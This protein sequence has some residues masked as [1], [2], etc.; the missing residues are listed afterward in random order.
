[1]TAPRKG[2]SRP[3]DVPAEVLARLN[4]GTLE[5]A[6]L[7][8]GLAMDFRT[9]LRAIEPQVSEDELAPLAPTVGISRRM[10][11]AADRLLNRRGPDGF[12]ALAVHP[13]D[14]V[15]GWAAY[16]LAR[17]PG[18]TLAERLEQLRPLA[19]DSHFG[20]REWAWLAMR[21]HLAADI[22]CSVRLLQ[23]WTAVASANLRR[24]AVESVRPCGVWCAHIAAL[25]EDPT[26]GLPLLE[27][28]KADRAKY[29]QD[30][31]AN[32]LNDAAKSKPDWVR[33]L[34][35][36]WRHDSPC[37]E[38]QRICHRAERSIKG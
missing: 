35:R 25:K 6:T 16:V 2:A 3:A 38:T 7:A 4:A 34:T 29:V 24:F 19:D 18:L 15:R 31:L 5:T 13:S 21:A 17:L 10:G 12:A 23:P 30:S 37:A 1:M 14:T 20:V 26:L 32:W 8:E 22:A 27:P 11:L 36:R 28:L 9:L 33:A